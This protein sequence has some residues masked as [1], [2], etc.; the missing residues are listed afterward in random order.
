MNWP[1]RISPKSADDGKKQYDGKVRYSSLQPGDR[2]LVRNL[3]ERIGPGKLRSH[4]EQE[5]HLIVQQKGN[6][7]VY[8][9]TPEGRKGRSRI[10][11]RNLL[12]PCDFLQSDLSTPVSQRSQERRRSVPASQGSEVHQHVGDSG[13]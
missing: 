8:E 4:W 3:S 9:V 10:L 6:L 12:L 13:G 11:H 5:V 2:V 7:P 1:G